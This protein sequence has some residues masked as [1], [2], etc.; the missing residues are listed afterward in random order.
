M[1]QG[2]ISNLSYETLRKARA[3]VKQVHMRHH[4]KDLITD[5]EADRIIESLGPQAMEKAVKAWVD[6]RGE[7]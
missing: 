4:P 2:W 3:V 6:T 5:R 1:A 7:L